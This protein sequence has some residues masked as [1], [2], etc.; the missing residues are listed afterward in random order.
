MKRFEAVVFLAL[1]VMVSCF[2]VSV[3]MLVQY[4]RHPSTGEMQWT[5]RKTRQLREPAWSHPVIHIVNTRFMQNQAELVDLARARLVLFVTFCLP[6]MIHQTLNQKE[7]TS[8]ES[9]DPPF[10]WVVKVDPNLDAGVLQDLTELLAPYPQFFLVGSNTN[11]G[12]GNIGEGGWRGG[13]AGESL[14]DDPVYTG[15]VEW[16]RRA[17]LFRDQRIVLET[18][19][20][21]DDGLNIRYLSAVQQQAM[22]HLSSTPYTEEDTAV[23]PSLIDAIQGD[24]S[25]SLEMAKWM[26]WCSMSHLEWDPFSLDSESL[27]TNSTDDIYKKFVPMR[28]TYCITPGL[29]LGAS[30]GVSQ[31]SL[32][33]YQHT[34]VM[35]QSQQRG[36][37]GLQPSSQCAVQI[38]D[39]I[40][41]AIRSRT[42]T[43][44]GMRG[45]IT[46]TN[47]DSAGNNKKGR[48]DKLG[49]APG[50]MDRLR[51]TIDYQFGVSFENL[52]M[53]AKYV[54]DHLVDIV[55]DNLRGQCT[56][57]H[58]C[59][60][61]A[62]DGLQRVLDLAGEGAI[63]GQRTVKCP[64]DGCKA[65]Q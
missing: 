59:K 11:Y 46:P 40:I 24:E 2:W 57:G 56:H 7:S 42:P 37:C 22:V 19:L 65:L 26:Y 20:D 54:G 30:V 36:D 60:T 8:P 3:M 64:N 9:F 16:L 14:L 28:S 51:N 23:E 62:K 52:L 6:T 25:S 4:D 12:V 1:V 33:R 47:A 48:L 49:N 27:T 18:R 13:E 43:S 50:F 39:P 15:N 29:T 44:A 34:S 5:R 31:Q 63:G 61:S 35:F 21:A 32:P 45:V 53:T 10:L 41:S 17:H 38:A 55:T 58:S